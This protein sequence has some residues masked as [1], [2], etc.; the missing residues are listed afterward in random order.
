MFMITITNTS[1]SIK[2][3]IVEI[4]KFP[5]SKFYE[6]HKSSDSSWTEKENE[7]EDEP[8]SNNWKSKTKHFW[9]DSLCILECHGHG[10]NCDA[11][12]RAQV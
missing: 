11:L 8:E 5:K 7:E 9:T 12:F 4:Q 3:Y 10:I 2:Y 1:I 6:K